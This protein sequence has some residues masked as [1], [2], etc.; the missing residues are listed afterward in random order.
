MT[1]RLPYTP[2]Y[3]RVTRAAAALGGALLLSAS[4]F[5]APAS[6]D[7]SNFDARLAAVEGLAAVQPSPAQ[8]DAE[9]ALRASVPDLA[10]EYS[11][12][13]GVAR[14]LVSHT[15]YLTDAA[16]RATA[17]EVAL[18]FARGQQQ[19]LGL[20]AAD[21]DS[22][23]I[24]DEVRSTLTGATHLYLRQTHAG[25][26]VYNG[27][28]QVN[29]NRDGRVMGLANAFVPSLAAVAPKPSA[30]LSAGAAVLA[31]A[32]HAGLGIDQA[33]A[34]QQAAFGDARQVTAVAHDGLAL[35]PITAELMWLPV[36][37]G[38]VRLVWNF[39]I[40]TLDGQHWY[41]FT[42]DATN[43]AV[44]TRFDWVADHSYR[45]YEQPVESP[46]HTS[47]LPPSDART[48]VV[49]P[50]DATAS[51][52]LWFSGSGIMDGN[53][54]HACAD[55][56]NNNVCDS[57]Q[58]SCSGGTC[59]FSIN[60]SSSPAN[61]KPAAIT[62]L[63]YW[64]NI[65]H[66]IQYQYGFDEPAGNFQENNFGR[67]GAGSDS[68][69]AQAQDGGGNCNA[70]FATPTDGSNPRMQMYLCNRASPSRDGDYDNGVIIHEYGH[71]ISIRQVGGPSNSSCLNNRQQ[72]GEGWS[73]I[74]AL[75]YTHEP[76]DAGSDSRGVGAYLF[77][78]PAV[79]GT[80]RDLPYSTSSS[81]NNWTYESISGSAVPH[82]VGSR[83]AQA[84]WEVY[85]ALV[86][87][88]GFESDLVNFD[89]SDANEAGNKR[90]MF[91]L[92]EG[93]KNTACSPTFVDNR[94]GII[95]AATDNFGGEDVCTIWE[96]F[97]AFGLGTNAVSGGSSSTN[98]SN[99]FNLPAACDGTPPPEPP[100]CATDSETFTTGGLTGYSNQ[101]ASNSWS[102]TDGGL[103]VNL[104]NNTWIRTTGSYSIAADTS[105]EFWY[106]STSEGEIQAIGFDADDDLNNQAAHFQ[107]FGTQNWT[108]TG[109]AS[110]TAASYTG[111]G[112]WQKLT[113]PVG[114]FYTGSRRLVFTNDQDSGS[115][116]N[117]EFR[118]VRVISGGGPGGGDC[119]VEDGFES[120]TAGWS[121]AAASTCSTGAYV[122][123]NPT[124]Q[125]S[126]VVTQPNGSHGG[127]TSIFTATN[128]A[129]G[130]NDV[131][132]GNCILDSP[133][134][135]VSEAS[136]LSLWYFHGQ[137]DTGDDPS[138]DFFRIEVSTNGGS[139][140]SSL[141]NIGDVRTV[142]NWTEVTTSIPAGSNVKLRVQTSDG[143]A[144]GDIVEGG[145]DDLSIC[146][147]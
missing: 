22:H 41:D 70:N 63:F 7:H 50:E 78:Y 100:T 94:D 40:E 128:T 37:R 126:T 19:L 49:N 32:R 132:G 59:D 64:N 136:T 56:D 114:T 3:A 124:Q 46:I 24:T 39:Q 122:E 12:E 18:D 47:P 60:L 98:P 116:A 95:Q 110:A 23:E 96:A 82:G 57:G 51:P 58:P 134:W 104:Q 141:V 92:N 33:P 11:A 106:R 121:N 25:L 109:N 2:F 115:G 85:W 93:L 90:A 73:D 36:R 76:G 15:G 62:N 131:D 13:F 79:G 14:T 72:A 9:S 83:W 53:N 4:A 65:I 43:G 6:H 139:S 112:N 133:T 20:S 8:L 135:A 35:S 137:R 48:L 55:T 75:M 102:V 127:T 17:L 44:M 84:Y 111:G 113:I 142:A 125:T 105:V 71:G 77:N 27:Q 45:V 30:R 108:G 99:G 143:S 80:I 31:A 10:V 68:V 5:G 38:D 1:V 66:D 129:A 52:N 74:L 88:W 54:V 103:Q 26:P 34:T 16:P 29:V 118:C 117:G 67:G 69:N 130:T 21:L 87:K 42:V 97:A 89:I 140:Y 120:G 138:G 107:F 145:I 123:G 61:S 86:D 91:Y 28:L 81:I 146:P 119:T 144:T 147:Q 101:N